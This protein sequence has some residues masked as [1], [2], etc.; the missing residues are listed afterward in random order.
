MKLK[1]TSMSYTFLFGVF[2]VVGL[3]F[4]A[5]GHLDWQLNLFTKI[6]FIISRHKY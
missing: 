3:A 6:S 2:I 4:Y 1:S 5:T